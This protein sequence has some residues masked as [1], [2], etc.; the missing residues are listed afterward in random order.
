MNSFN[1]ST[2]SVEYK[3]SLELQAF[4]YCDFNKNIKYF[5]AEPF[6][7][8]YLKPTTQKIHR[9]FPDLF[10]EFTSGAKFLVEV[11]HSSETKIPKKPKKITNKSTLN[12]N[13]SIQTFLINQAKWESAEKYCTDKGWKF[14]LLTEKE[15]L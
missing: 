14:I 13:K 2:N 1:E 15:L 4:R 7:I 5:S 10:I 9:Y 3:S 11:K 6:Y 8:P 12:Y